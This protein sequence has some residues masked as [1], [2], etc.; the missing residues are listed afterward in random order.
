MVIY[1]FHSPEEMK[2]IL[3]FFQKNVKVIFFLHYT[4]SYITLNDFQSFDYVVY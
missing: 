4:N 1:R 3:T 2:G